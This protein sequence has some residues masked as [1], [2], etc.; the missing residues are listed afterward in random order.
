V[1]QRFPEQPLFA[2]VVTWN[3]LDAMTAK[4]RAEINKLEAETGAILVQSGAIDGADERNR[5]IADKDSGYNGIPAA[6]DELVEDDDLDAPDAA[7]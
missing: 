1:R 7:E 5:L 4:E 6:E 2:P 3:P